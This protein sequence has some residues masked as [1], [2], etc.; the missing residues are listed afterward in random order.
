MSGWV[1][2]WVDGLKV[3]WSRVPVSD[4]VRSPPRH[5][6]PLS[7]NANLAI[8]RRMHVRATEKEDE[9]A[10]LHGDPEKLNE[11]CVHLWTVAL[12]HGEGKT[13]GAF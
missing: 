9:L 5:P 1:K 4:S 6:P 7:T 8:G 3:S 13:L 10:K 12:C 2:G 11:L